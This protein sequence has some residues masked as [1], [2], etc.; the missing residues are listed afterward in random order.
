MMYIHYCK[1]CRRIHILNGHKAY[2][3]ACSGKLQELR[4]S[5]LKYVNMNKPERIQ[6]REKC[7]NDTGLKELSVKQKGIPSQ[8][9]LN[10]AAPL[11][12][13]PASAVLL[14]T[15]NKSACRPEYSPHLK[16]SVS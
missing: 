2:C 10:A 6:L 5:Y 7:A 15:D 11:L 3:P 12:K 1:Y 4:I 9:W 13:K 14:P 8:G 16:V